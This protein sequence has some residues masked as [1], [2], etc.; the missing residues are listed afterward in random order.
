MPTQIRPCS[1]LEHRHDRVSRKPTRSIEHGDP[2]RIHSIGARA[3][4]ADPQRVGSILDNRANP[5]ML[6]SFRGGDVLKRS[7]EVC[8]EAAVRSH[9]Y[10]AAAARRNGPGQVALQSLGLAGG[11]KFAVAQS[12]QALAVA[13]D[14]ETSFVI[15][16]QCAQL[17]SGELIGAERAEF[18]IAPTHQSAAMGRD[19]QIS[20]AIG[21]QGSND[22]TQTA[23]AAATTVKWP[24]T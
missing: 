4:G 16:E 23:R 2:A 11:D 1:I 7:V 9:P 21:G 15:F 18:S 14:P 13:A 8:A 20:I 10:S 22:G 12:Q 6:L 3:L 5:N 19:P 24:C 17:A